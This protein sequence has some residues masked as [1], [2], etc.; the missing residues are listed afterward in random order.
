MALRKPI[1]VGNWKMNGGLS[2]NES[3][4]AAL[5]AMIAKDLLS[6]V[7]VAVSPAYVHLGQAL[8]ALAGSGISVGAQDVAAWDQGAYTGEVSAAMLAEIGCRFVL[9]GH[10][11]RRSLMGESDQTVVAK[12]LRAMAV[13]LDVIVCVGE[14]LQERESGATDSV[15]TRQ[16]DA[17]AGLVAQSR[18]A[19]ILIAYEP[20]W[21]IGTGRTASPEQAQQVHALIRARLA[22]A[23]A[24]A[25]AIRLLYGGSV[26][27]SN[28]AQLFSMPDIDGGLVGGAALV[29][30]EFVA[31]CRAALQ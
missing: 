21:A 17:V 29:A 2:A 3:L 4:L 19:K 8:G 9:V 7:D 10:S 26:K 30:D 13:G 15:I 31:I 25:G 23:G 12:A 16:V 14:T 6:R 24:D 22:H 20:V 1:V 28:A 5:R 11:E 27:A 18:D